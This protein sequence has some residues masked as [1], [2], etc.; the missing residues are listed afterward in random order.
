MARADEDLEAQ[1]EKLAKLEAELAEKT[2]ALA[3]ASE[4]EIETLSLAPRKSDVRVERLAL[5][6]WR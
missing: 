2:A 6:W 3:D 5:A 4:A 1:K